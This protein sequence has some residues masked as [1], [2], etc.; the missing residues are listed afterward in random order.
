MTR[1]RELWIDGFGCLRTNSQPFRFDTRRITLFL[2]ANEAGKTTLQ[3]ALLASLYGIET[4]HRVLRR[5]DACQLARPHEAHWKPLAGPP[6]GTRLRIQHDQRTLEIRWNFD[7]ADGL[8]ILDL[9]TNRDVT[10]DLC[11][12]GNGLHLGQRLLGLS[13]GE[14]IKTCLVQQDDLA[15]VRDPEGLNILVQRVAASQANGTTVGQAIEK[16][17]ALLRSYPGTMLKDGGPLD[18]ESA[19]L[20]ADI[21][22]LRRRLDELEAER[23][24]IAEEDAQYQEAAD[25]RNALRTEIARLDYLAQLAEHQELRQQIDAANAQLAKLAELQ[26]QRDALKD[27]DGFPC[28]LADRLTH[29]QARRLSLLSL[30]EKKEQEVADGQRRD[31]EPLRLRLAD[32]GKVAEATQEDAS[33]VAQLLGKTHDFEVRERDHLQAVAE[34]ESRLAARGA[35]FQEFQRLEERFADVDPA[36][37]A[38]VEA[39]DRVDAEAAAQI[40]KAERDAL[41][42]THASHGIR[43]A[44][45]RMTDDARRTSLVAILVA[46]IGTLVGALLIIL[47][48]AVGALGI[49][50]ALAAGTWLYRAGQRALA[51]A[52]THELGGLAAARSRLAQLDHRRETF[53]SER[54]R[55]KSRRKA[56]AHA[57]GYEQTEV[58][59]E[60]LQS[61]DQLGKLCTTLVHL[62]ARADGPTGITQKRRDLEADVG[63]LLD[64]FRLEH[65]AGQPL[66]APLEGLQ[67]QIATALR[68][69]QQLDAMTQSLEADRDECDQK[70]QSAEE[71]TR[72]IREA[73]AQ[74]GIRTRRS[75]QDAVVEF[76]RRCA[77]SQR[78]RQ[79]NDELIPHASEGIP[80][81]AAIKNWQE[82]ADRLHRAIAMQR[83]ERPSL[84]ALKVDQ[85]SQEYRRQRDARRADLERH[86]DDANR[87]GKHVL[88]V[89]TRYHTERPQ[90]EA[91]LAQQHTQLARARR[92]KAALELAI[93]VLGQIGDQVHGRWAEE[94][95]RRT[96]QLLQRITPTLRDFRFDPSL[97]FGVWPRG[98]DLPAQGDTRTPLL[99]AGTWDQLYLAVRLGL[100]DFVSRRGPGGLLILDDPF[101][102]FDDTR[103]RNALRLL[104]ELAG[105]RHQIIIFSCHHQRYEWLRAGDPKWFDQYIAHRSVTALLAATRS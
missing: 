36:D 1:I 5:Q 61:L 52:E 18:N 16:L 33:R 48:P 57:F 47:H 9:D 46:G 40:E 81:P 62:H 91:R 10:S 39:Y 50:A 84:L 34:E 95:N 25:K 21:G 38:F 67:D 70:R 29:W 63:Q 27:L 31:V 37:V 99:S 77:D 90:L 43:D 87:L 41:E 71:L 79:L 86:S 98:A 80:A 58:M 72:T 24:A 44:R 68:L 64:A 26:A 59:L 19:R 56:L 75:V 82:Q 51:L 105:D 102:H 7:A 49:L 83:E 45:K 13:L 96:G 97:R 35:S 101:S 32:L 88:D 85:P 8:R 104:A 12:D 54:R 42:A 55:R 66:S 3:M 4:D 14:F 23:Q 78:L 93:S 17:N 94:L 74:A 103:F 22:D 28:E 6:F 69:R 20:E 2:D 76:Q 89:L 60:D 65:H 53:T 100:A 30:A 92:H 11:P 73:L 15:R